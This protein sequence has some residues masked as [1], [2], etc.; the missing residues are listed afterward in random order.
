MLDPLKLSPT[1]LGENKLMLPGIGL[2]CMGLTEF[3]GAHTQDA[4]VKSVITHA[5]E[6][7]VVYLDTAD[8]YGPWRNEIEVGKAIKGRRDQIILSTKFGVVRKEGESSGLSGGIC[9]KADYVKQAC[10][11]SLK[12]LGVDFIDLYFMHRPDPD[13][14]IEETAQ[15]M[16][17]LVKDGKIGAIGFCEIDEDLLRRANAVH[18]VT[19]IQSEYSL[20]HRDPEVLFPAMKELNVGLVPYS[21]LGRG[22]LTGTIRSIEDLA[23]DDWRRHS[24]RFQGENFK[25]NLAIVDALGELAEQ[26]GCTTAQLAIAWVRSAPVPAVPLTG[27]TTIAQLD[28][29]VAALSVNLTAEDLEKIEAIAPGSAFGGASWPEGSAGSKVGKKS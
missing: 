12:R 22:F 13:T 15:A 28:E 17:E 7:G 1:S 4:D 19:A 2:G 8:A 24:P 27:A 18:P 20:W 14:P 10:D 21:P 29:N 25:N 5:I 9:G 26:K 23:E 6:K 16:G 11:E 3:Y